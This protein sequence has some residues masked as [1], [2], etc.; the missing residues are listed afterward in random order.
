MSKVRCRLRE[1]V[2]G[3]Q[4][5]VSINQLFPVI[6]VEWPRD[7]V[8]RGISMVRIRKTK[9]TIEKRKRSKKKKK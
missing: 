2:C 4:V 8:E 3:I 1:S 9:K 6:R 5:Q 7:H